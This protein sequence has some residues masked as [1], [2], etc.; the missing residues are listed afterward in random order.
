M[1]WT[2]WVSLISAIAAFAAVLVNAEY[3]RRH[4]R[5]ERHWREEGIAKR[6]REPLLQAS[7][8]LQSRIYNIVQQNFLDRFA[9]PA[10]TDEER[11]YAV[12]HTLYLI[13][14]YLC[15]VEILR[16]ESQFVDPRN[17]HRNRVIADQLEEIRD[18]FADSSDN[19]GP[20]R[21]FRGEQRA[22][23]EVMM[24]GSPVATPDAPRWDCIGYADFVANRDD[25]TF[26]RWF[27]CPRADLQVLVGLPAGCQARIV[28]VQHGLLGL[29]ELL[30][31]DGHRVSKTMRR[32][33]PSTSR[34]ERGADRADVG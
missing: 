21:I 33:L 28:R 2:A 24:V 31:P 11:Q 1:D 32:R 20:L 29:V 4:V 13:G 8:N 16:R 17:Q 10:N 19:A 6:F 30:D 14:Q 7:F 15:W 5:A 3:T 9:G 34:T 12:E 18:R 23:G 27:R 22:L 26:E 25:P